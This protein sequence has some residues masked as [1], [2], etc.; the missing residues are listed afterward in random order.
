MNIL[1]ILF[2][3]A[4]IASAFFVILNYTFILTLFG[5][6]NVNF[7]KIGLFNNNIII[8][9]MSKFFFYPSFIF[10]IWFWVD[11]YIF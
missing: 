11:I 9:P 6:S 10:Q 3:I 7:P 5:T 4:F 2:E 1:T 8:N